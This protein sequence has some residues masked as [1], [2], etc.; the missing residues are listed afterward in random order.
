MRRSK[1]ME[2][3]SMLTDVHGPRLTGSPNLRA[4]GEWARKTLPGPGARPGPPRALGALRARLE[5]GVLRGP[6]GQP[7]ALLPGRLPQGLDARHRGPGLRAR[8]S[9]CSSLA[10]EEDLK[11]WEGKLKGKFVFFA[12][13]RPAPPPFQAAAKRLT[14]EELA[15]LAFESDPARQGPRL[16]GMGGGQGD[17]PARARA[18]S[19]PRRRSCRST[20]RRASRAPTARPAGEGDQRRGFVARRMKFL[21]RPGR[22]GRARAG[23]GR[24]GRLRRVERRSR[25]TARS[26]RCCPRWC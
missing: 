23:A 26:R 11:A 13:P 19:R 12:P 14:D 16:P 8:W 1:V 5:P 7:A 9:W 24:L 3:A 4:A 6:R 22:A 2:Y 20:C 15:D 25:A 10:R 21:H 18:A 17:G